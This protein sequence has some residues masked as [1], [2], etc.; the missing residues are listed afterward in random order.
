MIWRFMSFDVKTAFLHAKLSTTI[1][2]KQI[3]GCPEADPQTVLHLLVALYGLRQSSYEFYML[4]LR[5]MVHLGLTHCEVDHAVFS[6]HWYSPPNASIPMP[7]DGSDLLLLIPVHVDDGLAV[8]NSIPLYT[9]FI[10]ELCKDIEVI[11]MG[12]VSLYLGIH[13]TRDHLNRKLY[14]SQK[15]FVTDLLDTWNMTNCHPIFVPLRHKL[16]VLPDAPL[17]S[18]P[19]IRDTDIKVNYQCLVGSLIYLAVCT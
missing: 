2:C 3:P 12:P 6:G 15:A 19:D 8:T 16:H 9:W 5:L 4:L 7:S 14:L 13:I 18:L 17:N 10:T 1:Y 11:D